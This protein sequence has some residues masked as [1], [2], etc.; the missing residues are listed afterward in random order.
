MAVSMAAMGTYSY[1]DENKGN[2]CENSTATIL[3]SMVS[4][5]NFILFKFFWAYF[6][7]ICNYILEYRLPKKISNKCQFFQKILEIH[8]IKDAS[9]YKSAFDLNWTRT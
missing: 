4:S 8:Y 5:N 6:S 7:I 2:S 9:N 3:Q 1:M